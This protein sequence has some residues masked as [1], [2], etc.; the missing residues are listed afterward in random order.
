MIK[1]NSPSAAARPWTV[2]SG[3]SRRK[4]KRRRVQDM[5]ANCSAPLCLGGVL[6]AVCEV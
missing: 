1:I 5:T 2:E 3:A 4:G 6:R